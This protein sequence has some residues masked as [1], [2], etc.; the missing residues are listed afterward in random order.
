[1][2]RI[3]TTV[4]VTLIGISLSAQ[5]KHLE[6]KEMIGGFPITG[7]VDDFKARMESF[8]NI[9]AYSIIQTNTDTNCT[10]L[11]GIYMGKPECVIGL[12]STPIT[13]TIYKVAIDYESWDSWFLVETSYTV[14]RKFVEEE[15]GKPTYI[16]E[17]FLDPYKKGDGYEIE[18]FHLQKA[19]YTTLWMTDNGNI[20]LRI[21]SNGTQGTV[22]IIFQ[23]KIGNELFKQE[24][25][26]SDPTSDS[27]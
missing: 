8:F 19:S 4:V 23:D 9:G 18:A 24:S 15:Y 17:Y 13:N 6:I 27:R 7:T 10:I 11:H 5:D 26:E 1:M 21:V 3:I 16:K 25:G 14:L 12:F 22:E 2:K 20:V